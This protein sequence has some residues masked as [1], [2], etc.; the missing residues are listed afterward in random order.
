MNCVACGGSDLV[1]QF[2]ARDIYNKSFG[3][4]G[5]QECNTLQIASFNQE[6]LNYAYNPTYYGGSETKFKWPFSMLFDWGK[7]RAAA[8]AARLI[9]NTETNLLDI[10]CGK[11]YFLE[12][13]HRLG[14]TRLWGNDIEKSPSLPST[15]EWI[16]GAFPQ[17]EVKE[18]FD[19]ITLAHVFEHI[20]E[21]VS[22]IEKLYDL[23]QHGGMVQLSQPNIESRQ[24]QLYQADWFHLDPPRHL[25]LIPA[26]QL[27]S[28]FEKA[29]FTLISDHYDSTL[30]NPFGYLQSW[31][32]KRISQRDLLYEFLKKGG[33]V[34]GFKQAFQLAFSLLFAAVSFPVYLLMS[35]GQSKR[36]TSGTVEFV[37]KKV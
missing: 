3:F 33:K 26:A 28:M 36:G 18:R 35:K 5:C 13:L 30:Y 14:Y 9:N 22:V 6:L 19:L 29:G 2:V 32:N 23:L 7:K 12:K 24:A 31:L 8:K 16:S 20:P 4:M 1:E 25:H 17:V 11:G 10:G 37:F 34:R 27:K 21:P 15:I